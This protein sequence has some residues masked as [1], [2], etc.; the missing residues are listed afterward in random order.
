[1]FFFLLNTIHFSR[2]LL[3]V[4]LAVALAVPVKWTGVIIIGLP[5][6]TQIYPAWSVWGVWGGGGG[7]RTGCRSAW[8]SDSQ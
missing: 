2:V 1:M 6:L 3:A 5:I 4:L 8:R 7:A